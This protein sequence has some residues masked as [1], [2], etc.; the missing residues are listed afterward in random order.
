MFLE[1]VQTNFLSIVV[2]V[3]VVNE[4]EDEEIRTGKR[5]DN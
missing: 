3:R 5:V 2:N 1:R 4:H